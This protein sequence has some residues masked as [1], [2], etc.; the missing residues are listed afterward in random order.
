MDK[1]ALVSLFDNKFKSCMAEIQGSLY[2][3][4]SS[5]KD[6]ERDAMEKKAEEQALKIKQQLKTL[7]ENRVGPKDDDEPY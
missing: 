4:M 6:V 2:M 5:F 1:S 7:P 3:H